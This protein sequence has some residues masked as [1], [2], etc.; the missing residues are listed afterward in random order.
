[1]APSISAIVLAA[2]RS[3]RMGREKALLE[4]D[5][6]PMWRRQRDLL[7][8]AGATEIFLSARPEQT[9]TRDTKGFAAVIHDAISLGGPIVGITAGLERASA[10][11]LAVLAVD[12]PRMTSEW[13][14]SLLA[15]STPERGVVG[16]REGMF[17]PL[18]AIY[19]RAMKWL[20]WE[21]LASARYALQPLLAKAVDAGL[22]RVREIKGSQ[23]ALF[24]NWNEDPARYQAGAR[25]SR[26]SPRG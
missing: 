6:E 16:R 21:A 2:G 1:M 9:W 14:V 8:R 25:W 3:T 17:E 12:L 18:A 26:L 20:A 22:L 11:V 4:V 15:E 13:F 5:G 19:P 7:A 23:T 10:P 24:Q